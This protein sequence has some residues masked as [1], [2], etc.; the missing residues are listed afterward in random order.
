MKPIRI[1][2]RS[3]R[4]ARAQA[5]L[6]ACALRSV[7]A[8][9]QIEMVIVQTRGDRDLITPLANFGGFG[10][11]V[12]ELEEELLLGT[13]DLAIHSAKDMPLE[14]AEGL[15]VGAVLPRG[16]PRDVL[17]M[18]AHFKDEPRSIGTSSVRR[19]AAMKKLFPNAKTPEIRGNVDTRLQKLRDGDYDAIVL[20]KAGLDR[21]GLS[22]EPDLKYRIFSIDEVVP[23]ACQGLLAIE[24]RVGEF[25]DLL[26]A[27]SDASARRAF[28]L[29]R[30]VLALFG[31]DCSRPIGAYAAMG[32][33]EITLSV[34]A[35]A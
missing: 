25:A 6:A 2:T 32:G 1:G 11:F 22:T 24:S 35:D 17:V 9:V 21:A 29:E 15:T 5:E 18:R 27:V 28:D 31:G 34:E 7:R 20:A 33:E 8:D 19:R 13:I 16:D 10:A 26:A 12:K 4:L 14:L 30:G 23:A 3:S